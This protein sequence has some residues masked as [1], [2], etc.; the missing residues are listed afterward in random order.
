VAIDAD[1]PS[2]HV[3]LTSWLAGL[4]LNGNAYT[5]VA[6]IAGID[7]TEET[8]ERIFE[9][10]VYTLSGV[11]PSVVPESEIDDAWNRAWTEYLVG[12][13][14]DTYQVVGY[15]VA[16]DGYIGSI[17]RRDGKEPVIQVSVNHRL[18]R[19]S[20]PDGWRRTYEHQQQFFAG[21][22]AYRHVDTLDLLSVVWGGVQ[23]NPGAHVPGNNGPGYPRHRK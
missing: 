18:A 7:E 14:P 22:T 15:E 19:L 20:L 11:D 12:I 23:V 3:R 13:D 5:T 17:R 6:G 21:D 2:G 16:F 9:P 4:T 1:F 8:V 10:R